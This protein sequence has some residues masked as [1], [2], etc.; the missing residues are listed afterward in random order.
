[1]PLAA[2]ESMRFRDVTA[3]IRSRSNLLWLVV[4]LAVAVIGI[5]LALPYIVKDYVNR[6]LRSLDG[7]DGHVADIDMGLWRGAYRIDRIEIVKIGAK[8]P[9]PFFQSDRVD[10]SIEWRSLLHGS[11]VSEAH[12]YQPVLNLVEDPKQQQSQ[13]GKEEDWHAR[14]EELFPFKFNTVEVHDGTITFRTPGIDTHDALTARKVNGIITNITNVVKTKKDAFA[15]FR[16]TGD[17]LGGAD[18]WVYGS[19][20]PFTKS[21]TFD[22]NLAIE[23]IDVPNVNP[24]LEAY[25]NADAKKGNVDLYMEVASAKGRYKGYAKPIVKDV[26]FLSLDEPVKHP[27]KSLWEGSLQLASKIFKNQPRDQVAAKVPFSGTI[28]GTNTD[29]LP[30]IA[31]VL[32]NAF[33]RAFTHS[34]DSTISLED[35]EGP[36]AG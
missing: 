3:T 18:A 20:E 22:L 29:V 10:L 11:L 13:L 30:A 9:K 1:M 14:L 2:E 35:V 19:A 23:K 8:Q 34:I 32:R 12:F 4:A 17:V 7:Y 24:W 16:M 15:D 6:H 5:R 28:A 21:M 26:Q 27:V 25:L 36:N 33:V 31:S